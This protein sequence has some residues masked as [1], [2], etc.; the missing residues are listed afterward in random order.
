MVYFEVF[1]LLKAQTRSLRTMCPKKTGFLAFF[2]LNLIS[3]ASSPQKITRSQFNEF[4]FQKLE[5]AFKLMEKKEF[6]KAGQI[7]DSL[8][9]NSKGSPIQI[10]SLYNAGLAYKSAG[11]C[12]TSLSRFRSVLD[13]SF[14]KL[15]EYQ[16]ISL[17]EMSLVYECLGQNDNS[18]SSLKDLEKKLNF[19]ALN[20]QQILYPA[21]LSIAWS[22]QGDF[23]KASLYQSIAFSKILEYKKRLDKKSV[24]EE[25]SRLFY[26]MG[27]SYVKKEYLQ[28]APFISSFL[29]HQIFLLQSLFMKNKKWSSKAQIELDQ[30]FENVIELLSQAEDKQKHKKIMEKSL[31]IGSSLVEKEKSKKWTTYYNKKSKLI[32]KALSHKSPKL[33]KYKKKSPQL[34]KSSRLNIFF[35]YSNLHHSIKL[36]YSS[37]QNFHSNKMFSKTLI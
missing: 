27:K 9:I 23:K 29:Y 37:K 33:K 34:N 6:L 16:A 8:S 3:C 5:E 32:Q 1:Y 17:L 30:L 36:T 19:L 22:K 12:K 11:N 21:R 14:K 25:I 7:Y 10:L 31:K 20:F 13:K 15:H 4:Q 2:I 35:D 24:K 28:E 26:L 18:L